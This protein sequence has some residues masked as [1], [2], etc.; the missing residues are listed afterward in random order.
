MEKQ[1]RYEGDYYGYLDKIDN[2]K[3][4]VTIFA[5]GFIMFRG[6]GMYPQPFACLANIIMLTSAS[7]KRGLDTIAITM[8]PQSDQGRVGNGSADGKM[9]LQ[10]RPW[11]SNVHERL[12]M[13]LA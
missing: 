13:G 12:L 6:S 7:A 11:D 8:I 1:R 4:L 9:S 2:K 3:L 10:S 5:F